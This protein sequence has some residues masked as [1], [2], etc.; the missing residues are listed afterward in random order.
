VFVVAPLVVARPA[1]ASPSALICSHVLG[2]RCETTDACS[3]E[4]LATSARDRLSREGCR[5]TEKTAP[6][7]AP[8]AL[9][10]LPSRYTS[11][12]IALPKNSR[13]ASN[14]PATPDA[15]ASRT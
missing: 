5:I 7:S 15:W 11:E 3:M 6:N 14:T 8:A 9:T 13:I 4:V 12:R 2:R 10:S 1:A